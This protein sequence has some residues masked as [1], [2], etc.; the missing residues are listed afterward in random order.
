MSSISAVVRD[1]SPHRWPNVEWVT[2]TALRPV[3]DA[4]DDAGW[5]EF[6]AQLAPL[7]RAAYPRQP[8]GTT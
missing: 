5:Q 7:L 2:G 4:L 1:I 8:D 3:R 6:I